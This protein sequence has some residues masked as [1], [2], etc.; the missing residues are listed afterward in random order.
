MFDRILVP[1]D[2]SACSQVAVQYATELATRYG[3]SVHALCVAD[4]RTLENAPH[5]DQIEHECAEIAADACKHIAASPV[6][7]ERAVR[8]GVPHR[9]ILRYATERGIDLVV[10]G[11][12]GRTGVDR[13]LLGS[14]TERVVRLSDVP[15]LTVKAADDGG[16]TYPYT[17]ILV[18]TD[19]SACAEAAIDPAVDIARAYDARLHAL[20]VVETV[21]MGVDIGSAE[22]FDA[23]E[24]SAR[25]AVE[26]V[27]TRAEQA[28]VPAIETA[29]L[30]GTPYRGIRSYV[31]D[32][33]VGL[34]AMG[35]HGRTG[36]GRY[37]LGSV[38]ERTV[39]T[40][41]VPVLTVR[42]DT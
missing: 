37:L 25:S 35:T 5:R 31:E 40:S 26:T 4:S 20:S 28:S 27:E 36:V 6:S 2:G 12:H 8:T 32:H 34:V 16:I 42:A 22:V 10:M 17:D 23:L 3:A 14:V 11:S 39:R 9:A 19:G 13:Y 38:T 33:D 24:A 7:A 41:P 1:V 18:P 15:V 29:V 21:S 30:H